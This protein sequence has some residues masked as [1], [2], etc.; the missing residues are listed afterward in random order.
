MLHAENEVQKFAFEKNKKFL[1]ENQTKV[2]LQIAY[3]EN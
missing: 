1:H 3:C 2:Y